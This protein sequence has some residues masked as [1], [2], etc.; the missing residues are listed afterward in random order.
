MWGYMS[1]FFKRQSKDL[2]QNESEQRRGG[3]DDDDEE[4]D[5]PVANGADSGPPKVL[6]RCRG[7]LYQQRADRVY[8]PM[9]DLGAMTVQLEAKRDLYT[10]VIYNRQQRPE[11]S[12]PVVNG[13]QM[14]FHFASGSIHWGTMIDGAVQMLSF[15]F[16]ADS[17][18]KRPAG[19]PPARGGSNTAELAAR[20]FIEQYHVLTYYQLLGTQVPEGALTDDS[21]DFNYVTGG[22][23]NE[24][25]VEVEYDGA[26]ATSDKPSTMP[27][28]PA[29]D[30]AVFALDETTV[31]G[32][33]QLG[34]NTCF[35][36]SVKF[37]RAIVLQQHKDGKT[38]VAQA[39]AYNQRGFTSAKFDQFVIP[40][41][42]HA[43]DGLLAFGE[44]H[45]YVLDDLD[46]ALV[47]LDLQTG[48]VVTKYQPNDGLEVDAVAHYEKFAAAAPL[49]TC[50]NH[51]AAFTVDMRLDPN[52]CVVTESG[53]SAAS[54]RYS[55]KGKGNKFTCHA[56]SSAGHLA[57][58]DFTGDV[59]L[60]TGP[61]GSRKTE[62]SGHHAK[63]AKTLLK[64]MIPI[65]HID[66]TSDG[67][68]VLVT[69]KSS[70]L[71]LSTKYSDDN[72]KDC[73]G[74][75]QRMG[76]NKPTPLRLQPSPK[77]MLEMGGPDRVNFSKAT[78][79]FNKE[80][81]EHWVVACSGNFILT[82]SLDAI[83]KSLA[84]HRVVPCEA[85]D[86]QRAVQSVVMVGGQERVTF[87][88]DTAVGMEMRSQGRKSGKF[89]VRFKN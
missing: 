83:K 88:S 41:V 38:I 19:K 71:V 68:F 51:N 76:K 15:R 81:G 66:I 72:G 20:D 7:T 77:Q 37:N 30:E 89:T 80:Q 62:G 17:E 6:F 75:A 70:L 36:D 3:D 27:Q 10:M 52:R 84:S 5:S 59:R 65:V 78:F 48:Q 39:H 1:S 35:A 40:G 54:L 14:N 69:T 4:D 16:V 74:F 45:M 13:L 42:K 23:S 82:W 8:V 34:T 11:L 32:T 33:G 85:K 61:P 58:A 67:A 60:F 2:A 53:E 29:A 24:V 46:R 79:E 63:L 31:S 21:D 25:P 49:V 18:Y 26:T 57:V 87:L 86:T 73:N 56:T 43:K 28:S 50:L 12:L 44:D 22:M 55:L 47:N 64:C 9:S